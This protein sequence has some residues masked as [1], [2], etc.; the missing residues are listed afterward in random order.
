[1]MRPSGRAFTEVGD[2]PGFVLA[3]VDHDGSGL[4]RRDLRGC[5]GSS[6]EGFIA[7]MAPLVRLGVKIMPAQQCS[8]FTYRGLKISPT[9]SVPL[10]HSARA[11]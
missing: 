11:L 7:A 4:L 2:A 8:L 9:Q 10:A 5:L 1:M 6:W 3:V